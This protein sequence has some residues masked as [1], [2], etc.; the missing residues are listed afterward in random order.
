MCDLNWTAW[1]IEQ[2]LIVPASVDLIWAIANKRYNKDMRGLTE[3]LRL[4]DDQLQWVPVRELN[5]DGHDVSWMAYS[6]VNSNDVSY[7]GYQLQCQCDFLVQRDP[8]S[9]TI[10]HTGDSHH[11]RYKAAAIM[12]REREVQEELD[13]EFA[14]SIR[15]G[16]LAFMREDCLP[17]L[18]LRLFARHQTGE[19]IGQFD[20]QALYLQTLAH[21]LDTPMRTLDQA[22]R[23]LM[24]ERRI[25]LSGAILSEWTDRF[26][27]HDDA[28]EGLDDHRPPVG[29][30]IIGR[31][32]FHS[33]TGTEGGYWAIQDERFISQIAPDNGIY[34]GQRVALSRDPSRWGKLTLIADAA[35]NHP[36]DSS[37][38]KVAVHYD[39]NTDEVTTSDQLLIERWGY[40]GLKLLQTGDYL[41][42]FTDDGQVAWSG[43]I[44]LRH[45]PLFTEAANGMW[46]HADQRGI[47][48]DVWAQFFF[49][50]AQA[51]L[52]EG[53]GSID[54]NGEGNEDDYDFTDVADGVEDPVE[55][56]A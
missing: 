1:P 5:I 36:Q 21:I 7:T 24:D 56:P 4:T 6:G 2:A 47:E 13:Q 30:P 16:G 50:G 14:G 25:G 52:I 45:Y 12:L 19:W 23:K 35:G 8:Q 55:D 11:C 43:Y 32:D 34:L 31:L 40:E 33:E 42:I 22:A 10:I 49:D 41:T 29:T 15:S 51:S 53:H 48:R 44:R 46:I 20:D 9:G 39:D 27:S 54:A 37:P 18:L 28:D 17:D 26:L 3:Y 38:V